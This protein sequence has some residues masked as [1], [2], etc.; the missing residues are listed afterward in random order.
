[1]E[2]RNKDEN[3]REERRK[4]G[5]RESKLKSVRDRRK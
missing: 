2:G 5:K 4:R 1:L 3:M